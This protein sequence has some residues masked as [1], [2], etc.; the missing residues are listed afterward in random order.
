MEYQ[1]TQPQH[2]NG[3]RFRQG[4]A[5]ICKL[6]NLYCLRSKP[7]RPDVVRQLIIKLVSRNVEN[8]GMMTWFNLDGLVDLGDLGVT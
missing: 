3:R 6:Y 5:I 2:I 1:V 7:L 8:T 4:F